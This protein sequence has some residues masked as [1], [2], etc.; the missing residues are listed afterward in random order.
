MKWEWGEPIPT[1]YF[2]DRLKTIETQT[3]AGIDFSYHQHGLLHLQ[4][5]ILSQ[6]RFQSIIQ[7][8]FS[9]VLQKLKTHMVIKIWRGIVESKVKWKRTLGGVISVAFCN[10]WPSVMR[11]RD[12]PPSIPNCCL[13]PTIELRLSS[14]RTSTK[15]D[16]V[17]SPIRVTVR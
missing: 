3:I 8:S 13:K 10:R 12:S 9:H 1:I 14:R 7:T 15:I 16:W 17:T 4:W 2:F 6:S 5:R 11:I